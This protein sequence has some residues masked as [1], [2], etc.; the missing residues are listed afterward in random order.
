MM[1]DAAAL[2][3]AP[4]GVWVQLVVGE[5]E[6]GRRFRIKPIPEDVDAL[7]KAVFPEF[8]PREVAMCSVFAPGIDPKTGDTLDPGDPVP[9]NTVK[10]DS[11]SATSGQIEYSLCWYSPILHNWP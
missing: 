9:G 8:T 11:K 1:S 7:K 4:A 5:E 6:Q 3:V 10:S 2:P